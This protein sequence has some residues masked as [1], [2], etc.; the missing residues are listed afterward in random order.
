MA[1]SVFK[2]SMKNIYRNFIIYSFI[3]SALTFAL[4][5]VVLLVP[6]LAAKVVGIIA[7]VSCILSGVSSLYNY[8][9]RDGAKLFALSILFAIVYFGI[10]LVLI[11]W[12]YKVLS[13]VMVC[14]GIYLLVKGALK[15]DYAIWLRKGEEA[16]WKVTLASGIVL[17]L[18]A[19]VMLVNPF[20][21]GLTLNQIIGVYLML[22]AVVD[23][24]NTFMF[25]KRT[26]EIMEIFW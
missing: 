14:I 18:I 19:I 11:I 10:A 24:S 6:N 1:K 9:K 26:K 7:G 25:N 20:K 15:I 22:L 3:S 17:I 5:L 2:N 23:I 4:G 16:S 21:A 12:P 8:L 13:F